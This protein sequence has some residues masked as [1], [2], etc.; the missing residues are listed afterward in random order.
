MGL[1]GNI[2]TMGSFRYRPGQPRV[3]WLL[4]YYFVPQSMII[5][6][7]SQ[8]TGKIKPM[9]PMTVKIKEMEL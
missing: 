4:D 1:W 6:I 2:Y 8:K 9:L 5:I 3:S 7:L